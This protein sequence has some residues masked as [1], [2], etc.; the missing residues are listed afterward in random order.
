MSN[1][2][3]DDNVPQADSPKV[4]NMELKQSNTVKHLLPSYQSL[5]PENPTWEAMLHCEEIGSRMSDTR[6]C[7]FMAP[8]LHYYGI[9]KKTG[10][11]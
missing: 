5:A 6:V 4:S 3:D 9:L 10:S 8:I 1:K 2:F 11:L 7:Q